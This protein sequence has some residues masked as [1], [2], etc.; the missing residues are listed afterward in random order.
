MAEEAPKQADAAPS[1]A[2]EAAPPVAPAPAASRGVPWTLPVL[3]MALGS[4]GGLWAMF[5]SVLTHPTRGVPG[6]PTRFD[7]VA[8]FPQV[9]AYAGE[10]ALFANASFLFVRA[11]G[12]MD[13]TATPAPSPAAVYT[14]VRRAESGPEAV[15][16]TVAEPW[17]TVKSGPGEDAETYLC[18]GMDRSTAP[19]L[20][21]PPADLPAPTCAVAA[22]FEAA[23]ERGASPD[24]LATVLYDAT[25]YTLMVAR[26]RLVVHYGADCRAR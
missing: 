26:P 10:G 13:L 24:A 25:G 19:A 17:R 9:R 12:T 20:A 22:L 6:E 11:D 16:V 8:A 15:T 3:V 1:V 23:R 14:F 7:P 21:S 4:L 5:G 2:P 18:R